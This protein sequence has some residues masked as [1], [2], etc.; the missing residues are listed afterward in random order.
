M[1]S[2]RGPRLPSGRGRETSL[3]VMFADLVGSTA[4]STR[5]DP[6][7]LREIIGAYH[8]CC[9]EQMRSLAVS[10]PDH[11]RR[12]VAYFGYPRADE[13]DAERAVCA[14]LG[15]GR[16]RGRTSMPTRRQDC[17]CELGIA[18]GLVIISDHIGVGTSQDVG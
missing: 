14:G 10:L 16:G 18:T 7:D 15:V 5:L 9:A 13:D 2:D 4:L 12:R 6:E 8:R 17:E 11:G 1:R 3:T